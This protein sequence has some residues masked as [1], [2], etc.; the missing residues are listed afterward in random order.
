MLSIVVPAYNEEEGI[1]EVLKRIDRVAGDLL[2]KR[3]DVSEIEILVINDG[4]TDETEAKARIGARTR[5]ITHASN[6]GYGAALKTGFFQSKGDVIVFLDADGTYPPEHLENLCDP[7]LQGLADITVATRS[8]QGTDGM[9][10]ARRV[11]NLLFARFLSWIAERPVSDSAS[12]MRAFRKSILPYLLPLP[13][14]LDFIAGLSTRALHE[15]LR[16][17][18]IPI[19]YARRCGHSKLSIVKDGVRFLKTFV[20]TAVTYNPLKFFGACGLTSLFVASYLGIGPLSFYMRYRRVDDWEIYRLLTILVLSI[21]GLQLI[22]FG[23]IGNRL[24][25]LVSGRP[26]ETRSLLGRLVLNRD[27][28]RASWRLGAA[29]CMAAVLLNYR[30]IA[31]YLA[32]RSI[33]VH[34][35]YIITGATMFLVGAQ[36]LMTGGLLGI[37]RMIEERQ[38]NQEYIAMSTANANTNRALARYRDALPERVEPEEIPHP[39]SAA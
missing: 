11:G 33:A 16:V 19:P 10:F 17:L 12:G 25:A 4:S 20:T 34:W 15:S 29:L 37:F 35:S 22:N 8:G 36:L 28:S 1:S 6:K 21:I 38:A 5:I 18:E 24:V 30:A 14:G 7:V 9:S 39:S 26:V 3:A 31:Q 32:L 23:I 13:D 2:K 27:F